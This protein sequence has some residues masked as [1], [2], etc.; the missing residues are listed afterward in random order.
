MNALEG[1]RHRL[2]DVGGQAGDGLA[3]RVLA[4]RRRRVGGRFAAQHAGEQLAHLVVDAC[5]ARPGRPRTP[6]GRASS[7]A[8]TNADF[9]RR[10]S[11]ASAATS[12][13]SAARPTD[14]RPRATDPG[15][16]VADVVVVV[17]EVG[18][19]RPTTPRRADRASSARRRA[20]GAAGES[21]SAGSMWRSAFGVTPSIRSPSDGFVN[22]VDPPVAAARTNPS[23]RTDGMVRDVP[24][25]A[26]PTSTVHPVKGVLVTATTAHPPD[27]GRPDRSERRAAA[28]DAHRG[29]SVRSAGAWSPAS[30]SCSRSSWLAGTL[31]TSCSAGRQP[32]RPGCRWCS[33]AAGSCTSRRRC[34]SSSRWRCWRWPSCCG[35]ASA[36]TGRSRSCGSGRPWRRGRARRRAAPVRRPTAPRGRGRSPSSTCSPPRAVAVAVVAHGAHPPP[37]AGHGPR[38]QRVP[39]RGASCRAAEPD[40]NAPTDFDAELLG[41]VYDMALQPLDQF[42]GFDWGEQIHGPTCV[43][44][45]LNM[46]GYALSPCTPPTTCRTPRSRSRRR[47]PT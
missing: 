36:P 22:M 19:W 38:A 37:Q 25:P 2:A 43:R 45:Q 40:P 3:E 28:A 42:R 14:R 17:G 41:W 21:P 47:S 35:G 18:G 9:S 32:G 20:A 44:Y 39:R 13:T 5:A 16:R 46:L 10:F 6:G 31:L 12:T 11:A 30:S 27:R 23:D 26:R 24:M 1:R 33:P 34:G 15:Q 8:A 4:Q 7:I 29:A